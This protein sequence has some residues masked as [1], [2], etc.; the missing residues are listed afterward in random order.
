MDIKLLDKPDEIRQKFIERFVMPWEEFQVVQKEWISEMSKGNYSIDIEW[1]KRA[2]MW[3][4][5]SA[6]FPRVSMKEAL[7]FLR[8]RNNDVLFM[9]EDVSDHAPRHL[10]LQNKKRIGFIA[11]T[12]SIELAT[13]VE[14]EWFESDIAYEQ[15]MSNHLPILPTDLYV[16][17]FSLNWCVVFTHE[18]TDLVHEPDITIET[19]DNR[20]CI[21]CSL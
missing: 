11:Q 10:F 3:D 16:F 5:M 2:Y 7:D 12:A 4:K 17:D 14:K 1:Y 18:T 19:A 13:L 8:E 20:Y 21:I 15:N 6:D 9:S